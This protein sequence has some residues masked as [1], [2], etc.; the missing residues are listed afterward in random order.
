MNKDELIR[1][2]QRS[3]EPDEPD[4]KSTSIPLWFDLLMICI[5]IILV[6]LFEWSR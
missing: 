6:I 2:M 4:K 5:A 1:I 3:M